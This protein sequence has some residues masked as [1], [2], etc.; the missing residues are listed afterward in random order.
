MTAN[1]QASFDWFWQPPALGDPGIMMI[2]DTHPGPH[3]DET[4]FV[5]ED[6]GNVLLACESRIPKDVQLYQLRIY[7]KD[8]IGIW[9]EIEFSVLNTA[10]TFKM[11]NPEFGQSA[12]SEVW[13]NHEARA[14]REN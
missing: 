12:L 7:V 10:R 5:Q 4:P 2:V 9:V 1:S 8:I 3:D 13:D 11:K 6:I 14:G